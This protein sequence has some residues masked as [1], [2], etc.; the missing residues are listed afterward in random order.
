MPTRGDFRNLFGYWYVQFLL[1]VT[2]VIVTN[3]GKTLYCQFLCFTSEIIF[4]TVRVIRK[5]R[6]YTSNNNI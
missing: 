1:R 5:G 4:I 6:N 3:Y 2:Q